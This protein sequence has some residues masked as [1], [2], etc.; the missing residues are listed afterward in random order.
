MTAGMMLMALVL[1]FTRSPASALVVLRGGHGRAASAPILLGLLLGC[2]RVRHFL[3]SMAYVFMLHSV[4]GLGVFLRSF[5][6]DVVVLSAANRRGLAGAAG[7][8]PLGG[9]F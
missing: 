3:L 6:S 8:V 2:R 9:A 1:I 4:A 7:G 5:L